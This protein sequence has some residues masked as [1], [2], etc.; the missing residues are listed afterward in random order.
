MARQKKIKDVQAEQKPEMPMNEENS[1]EMIQQEIDAARIELENTKR[2]IEE[3]KLELQKV[4]RREISQEERDIME[5]RVTV[6]N[7]RE[8]LKNKIERQREIDSEMIT[9]K[10]INRRAPGQPVKLP[11]IKHNTDPV[12][13]YPLEDGKVYT[14]PRGFANQL[15]G[16][17]DD[18]PCY[19]TPHFNQK[20][21]EMDPNKPASAIHSVD[22]SNKKYAFVP[23]SF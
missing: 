19:Y 22:T 1:V 14:I 3:K 9:G 20:V 16:G 12:K 7:N 21:G 18:D 15:N 5:N 6:G 17:T 10:F 8:A 23:V 13:W 2:E 4:P 11:Y